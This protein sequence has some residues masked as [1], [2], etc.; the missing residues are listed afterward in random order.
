MFRLPRPRRNRPGKLNHRV[1]S[2]VA[3]RHCEC[4]V[5][6]V[7]LAL[8]VLLI[9]CRSH[10]FANDWKVT[11]LLPAP[12]AHQAAAAAG[13]AIYAITNRRIAKYDRATGKRLKVSTGDAEHLNSGFFWKGRLYAAH[14]NY[15]RQPETS[16]IM[17]LD[18]DSMRLSIVKDFGNYGGSLTWVVRREGSWWCNFAR[19]GAVNHE[20]FLARFDDDWKE[21]GRWTYPQVVLKRIGRYSLSGGIWLGDELLVTD[22]DNPR[23]YRLV[24]PKSGSVLEYRGTASVPFSGQGFAVDPKSNGLIGIDRKRKMVVFAER[25]AK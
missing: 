4:V 1:L 18:P 24:L 16:R 17:Q 13:D 14:S 21:L 11:R 9:M 5:V 22:H 6:R 19:Y 7:F 2:I 12:E 15:P 23:V 3:E 25:A 8:V 20:T 10:L